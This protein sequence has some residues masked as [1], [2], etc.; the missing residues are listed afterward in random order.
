MGAKSTIMNADP[1]LHKSPQT[2]KNSSQPA[3]ISE[4]KGKEKAKQ[5]ENIGAS[6]PAK[7][8][9]KADI[10]N[11]KIDEIRVSFKEEMMPRQV[12]STEEIS[13]FS[14][15]PCK[16]FILAY[17]EGDDIVTIIP[18]EKSQWGDTKSIRLEIDKNKKEGI[19]K[20]VYGKDKDQIYYALSNGKLFEKILDP[21]NKT[22]ELID[23]GANISIITFCFSMDTLFIST[24][25]SELYEFNTESKQKCIL[26]R[27]G[28]IFQ[29]CASKSNNL[30]AYSSL[31]HVRIYSR[32]LYWLIFEKVYKD[33]DK[34]AYVIID[35]SKND[36]SLFC[37]AY[38]K[39]IQMFSAT[40]WKL[41]N[42]F[43]SKSS[44]K[45]FKVADDDTWIV[46]L[47]SDFSIA[48][49]SILSTEKNPV[50]VTSNIT[51]IYTYK[52]FKSIQESEAR[53][54]ATKTDA[55][56][57][58]FCIEIDYSNNKIYTTN[59][60]TKQI[61]CWNGPFL[62]RITLPDSDFANHRQKILVIKFYVLNKI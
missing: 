14:L 50:F 10:I 2:E 4:D 13:D 9:S 6:N 57:L 55:N 44:I 29:I 36:D 61:L 11:E 37:I 5:G 16:T 21:T 19:V 60:D 15:S 12:C 30:I 39:S 7:E 28:P 42:T 43:V 20:V 1:L 49:W 22:E 52:D 23:F 31:R 8:K 25:K 58:N 54:T 3:G 41:T 51:D 38:G 35:F 53:A 26:D 17:K 59:K 18:T 27:F 46:G 24:S 47:C 56:N 45:E 34:N 33:D 32:T 48:V 62:D 40:N